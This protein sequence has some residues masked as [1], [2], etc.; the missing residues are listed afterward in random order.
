MPVQKLPPP[1][2]CL[3]GFSAPL[4]GQGQGDAPPTEPQE[5]VPDAP[6]ILSQPRD[7][8]IDAEGNLYVQ[9]W[10]VSGRLMKLV[11]VR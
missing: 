2:G 11:R 9:D 4:Q 6:G 8:D 7:G 5:R 1:A 10:N 3:L